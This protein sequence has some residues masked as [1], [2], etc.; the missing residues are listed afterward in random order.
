LIKQSLNG[1]NKEKRYIQPKTLKMIVT[2]F[3]TFGIRKITWNDIKRV[4]KLSRTS[5]RRYYIVF[6][7]IQETLTS[8]PISITGK[9]NI[10]NSIEFK[11]Q[12]DEEYHRYIRF[13][14][15]FNEDLKNVEKINI[16]K[17]I[18][19]KKIL[20]KYEDKHLSS[21]FRK[22]PKP[23][24]FSKR[25]VRMYNNYESQN[26]IQANKRH[27][28]NLLDA[29]H[30]LIKTLLF[31]GSKLIEFPKG[32]ATFYLVGNTCGVKLRKMGNLLTAANARS[33]NKIDNLVMA[34]YLLGLRDH[35]YFFNMERG[36]EKTKT[37]RE[38]LQKI[39]LLFLF[40]RE[41]KEA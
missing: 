10:I 25:A 31:K 36:I 35:N 26:N 5:A 28:I 18:E 22:N 29:G 20:L 32:S 7:F 21:Y 33:K 19:L 34:C 13:G 24:L 39:D 23:K 8:D 37:E 2:L 40:S 12:T 38:L 9:L 4:L 1:N 3:E 17:I 27:I 11:P 6:G 15:R 30:P 14:E 41:C 16:Q